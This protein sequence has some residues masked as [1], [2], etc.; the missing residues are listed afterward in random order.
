M[1]KVVLEEVG[2]GGKVEQEVSQYSVAGTRR[3]GLEGPAGA[4]AGRPWELR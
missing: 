2:V 1:A 4:T 3:L